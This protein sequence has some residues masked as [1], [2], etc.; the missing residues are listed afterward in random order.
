[1]EGYCASDLNECNFEG[2]TKL[3]DSLNE[4]M[5]NA[6]VV[7]NDWGVLNLIKDNYDNFSIIIGRLSGRRSCPKCGAVYHIE[8]LKPEVEGICDKD[9]EALVQREDDKPEVIKN[10]LKNSKLHQSRFLYSQ[11]LAEF[12]PAILH[13]RK[14]CA[15]LKYAGEIACFFKSH[16]FSD[17]LYSLV[18]GQQQ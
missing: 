3:L 5:P 13:R 12:C 17:F 6:E 10:R 4:R 14:S 8:N 15:F 1:M 11:S 7:V 9:G 18:A 16:F 2:I